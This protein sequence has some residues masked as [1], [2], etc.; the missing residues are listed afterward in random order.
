MKPLTGDAPYRE[1][2]RTA[3]AI[4]GRQQAVIYLILLLASLAYN[5]NFVLIDYVRPFLA[6]HANMTL[7]Q[8]AWLYTAQGAGIMSGSVIVPVLISRF[9]SR[10]V[11]ILAM[12]SL[13]ILTICNEFVTAFQAWLAMRFIVGV[14]L[15]GT[16]T[17]SMTMLAN[18]FPPHVR[19]RL[20]AFNMAMF[21]VALLS[22]GALGALVGEDGWRT[23]VRVGAVTPAVAAVLVVLFLPD[24]RRY[25]V[26]GDQ[27]TASY[28]NDVRGRWSEM[29]RGRRLYL[30]LACLLLAGLNFSAYQFY[31]GFITTYLVTVRH[32]GASVTGL[33][34]VVDGLGTLIGSVFWGWIA[35]RYG[36]RV[37]SAGFA[38]AAL[39]TLIFLVAPVSVRALVPIELG[40]A[41]C[42]SCTNVWGAYFAELFPVRLRPMGTSLFHGGH[43][44]SLFAP[45]I[46]TV[47]ASHYS[48]VV[49]MALAPATFL[50]GA[51]VWACLPET[52]QVGLLYRGFSADAEQQ[53]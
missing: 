15:T 16:Y 1:S 11:L 31:S 21:S 33:F 51:L 14:M 5:Y 42:L 38:L 24:D 29:L 7:T 30:T 22:I 34:V 52:L 12:T 43:V 6:R 19:G 48:L 18:L 8:T 26:Y 35:D 32:F 49:G 2:P 39:F 9:G 25:S 47:I 13:C 41:I 4:C 17:A 28:Q 45:I 40:Y 36:R 46:V 37:N 27:E 10:R 3:D 44:V 20:L 23:L 53:G 50:A